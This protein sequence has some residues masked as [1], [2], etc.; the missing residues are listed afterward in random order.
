[1]TRELE[2]YATEIKTGKTAIVKVLS[3]HNAMSVQEI[4]DEVFRVTQLSDAAIM[5]SF[6][7]LVA[8]GAIEVH[9]P[10]FSVSLAV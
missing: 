10:E 9:T 1:M 7:R 4:Q 6:M 2:K 3:G 5:R 8:D